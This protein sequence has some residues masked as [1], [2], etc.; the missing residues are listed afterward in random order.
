MHS[1]SWVGLVLLVLFVS[2]QPV[3]A[4]N[5]AGHRITA[6]IAYQQLDSATR[7]KVATVLRAHPAFVNNDWPSR[8]GV[9][10]PDADLNLF[11]NA[12]VF[13][14]DARDPNG[15]YNRFHEATSHYVNF[16]IVEPRAARFDPAIKLIDPRSGSS[17]LT[18]YP[19][20]LELL[21]KPGTTLEEQALALSWVFHLA[22]DVHQPMHATARFSKTF[23][24]GDRGGNLVKV[25]N[26]RGPFGNLHAYW[27]DL[28]GVSDSFSD[29]DATA[30]SIVAQYPRTEL[31]ELEMTQFEGW[32][33]ES[34]VL[35]RRYVYRNLD[36]FVMEFSEMPVGYDADARRLAR[37][38]MALAGYRLAD[39]LR[40]VYQQQQ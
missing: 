17:V 14:D 2:N 25:P 19:R 37:R 30:K 13:P 27:D 39:V 33:Q 10:G 4:W 1:R 5:Y 22:G 26:P 3:H 38:R 11:L 36:P 40:E 29:V 34:V 12:S 7:S 16:P 32:V 20:K 6:W 23:P 24:Q 8:G 35:S 9:N 18:A 31:P 15:K 21:E 28:A